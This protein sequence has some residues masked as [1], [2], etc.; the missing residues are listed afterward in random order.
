MFSAVVQWKC[1]EKEGQN[2]VERG[3]GEMIYVLGILAFVYGFFEV[4]L[5]K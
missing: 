3:H 5:K 4:I 2:S 1:E